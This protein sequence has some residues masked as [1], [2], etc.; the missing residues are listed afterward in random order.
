VIYAKNLIAAAVPENGRIGWK[1]SARVSLF[2]L[3]SLLLLNAN[4]VEELYIYLPALPIL[5]WFNGVPLEVCFFISSD[6]VVYFFKLGLT[7][8]YAV[9]SKFSCFKSL[10][11]TDG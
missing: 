2:T 11:S 7:K 5:V 10:L 4:L 3:V 1:L 9:C 6:I 8:L